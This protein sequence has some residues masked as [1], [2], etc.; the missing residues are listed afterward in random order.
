MNRRKIFYRLPA[1]AR[2]M[3]RQLYYLPNDI[4]HKLFSSNEL[5]PPKGQIYTGGGDF[6]KVGEKFL[7]LFKK[8]G[9][10]TPDS[11]VLDV[12]SGIGRMAIPLT[13]Y[14]NKTSRY[15][16][17]DVVEKGVEW[18]KNNISVKFS[19]FNFQYVDLHNDLYK[20]EGDDATKFKFPYEVNS[21][22]LV[23]L[24]SVFTH[25]V[26]SE[27]IHYL[28]EIHAVLKPGGRCFATFFIV[29]E[30]TSPSREDFKFDYDRGTYYL[31]DE[32]VQSANVAFKLNE[33]KSNAEKVG[34]DMVYLN[35]GHWQNYQ[36]EQSLDFQ[37]II[38]LEK[39]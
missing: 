32:H 12:G 9:H 26:E 14:L 3:L 6:I 16:G 13:K 22:D 31:M 24:I 35:R 8:Y 20:S 17:F 15:E 21:F 23:I 29:D 34:F 5:H 33:L 30:H 4:F 27:V 37:D 39:N 25:M 11:N 38:V 10:L 18:C 1:S 2:F 28:K 19:N 36:S 7:E